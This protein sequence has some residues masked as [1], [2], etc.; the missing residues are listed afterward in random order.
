MVP[1]S[2]STRTHSWLAVYFRSSGFT[3]VPPDVS[4]RRPLVERGRNDT[5]SR[6]SAA[7]VHL[8]L[9]PDG[10]GPRRQERET[11]RPAERRRV[12][13]GGHDAGTGGRLRG[14]AMARDPAVRHLEAHQL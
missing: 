6:R 3:R 13:P 7:N 5:R 1:I 14:I 9:G 2:P 10:G 12:R 4:P 11:D 8:E